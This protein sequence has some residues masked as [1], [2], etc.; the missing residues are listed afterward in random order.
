MLSSIKERRASRL[1]PPVSPT[2]LSSTALP[3]GFV[4]VTKANFS[5]D[6]YFSRGTTLGHVEPD[7]IFGTFDGMTLTETAAVPLPA[8]AWLLLS[9]IAGVGTLARRRASACTAAAT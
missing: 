6:F 8:A 3:H 2:L 9:G 7:Y 5:N 4:D 1:R